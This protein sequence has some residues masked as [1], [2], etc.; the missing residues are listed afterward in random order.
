MTAYDV[1]RRSAQQAATCRTTTT[2]SSIPSC[3][4]LPLL[5]HLSPPA[6]LNG[7]D[8]TIGEGGDCGNGGNETVKVVVVV[9][10]TAVAAFLEDSPRFDPGTADESK[11]LAAV[12]MTGIVSCVIT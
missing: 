2:V 9:I 6:T 1:C 10:M 12:L 4:P 5:P 11:A 7:D 8:D 3:P